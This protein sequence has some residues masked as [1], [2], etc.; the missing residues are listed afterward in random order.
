MGD[1]P[2]AQDAPGRLRWLVTHARK[3]NRALFFWQSKVET[4]GRNNDA[5]LFFQLLQVNP[6]FLA[7]GRES[8]VIST[9]RKC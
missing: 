1:G 4:R 2:R 8:G 5:C 7:A 9:F 6:L 3:L